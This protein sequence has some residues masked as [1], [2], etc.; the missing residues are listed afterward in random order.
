M[1]R[2]GKGWKQRRA[3]TRGWEQAR[4]RA[5]SA[6]MSMALEQS[7]GTRGRSH[8][9]KGDNE[10]R[11]KGSAYMAR[12]SELRMQTE[13]AQPKQKRTHKAGGQAGM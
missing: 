12:A 2:R 3:A 5:G 6:R 7:N 8:R 13:D 11:G 4:A 9:G 1:A 10:G